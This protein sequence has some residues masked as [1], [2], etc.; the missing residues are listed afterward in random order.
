MKTYITLG[1]LALS[2]ATFTGCTQN[3]RA[4]TW[5]GSMSVDVPADQKL[6]NVTWKEGGNFWVL[7]RNA[8]P[9]EPREVYTFKEKSSFGIAEG[10][11]VITEK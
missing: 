5:G 9:G 1:L 10:T 6:V 7:T 4:R 3:I 2:I 8:R 11:V